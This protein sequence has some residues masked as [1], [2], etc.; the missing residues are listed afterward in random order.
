MRTLQWDNLQCFC[1]LSSAG[2]GDAAVN[3]ALAK[4]RRGMAR[5]RRRILAILGY[6]GF[7]NVERPFDLK[8]RLT[9][10]VPRDDIGI[11]IKG[12][13]VEARN[14]WILE[15]FWV[16]LATYIGEEASEDDCMLLI[17]K[18]QRRNLKSL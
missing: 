1:S 8:C 6:W 10:M 14:G 15:T 7:V 4:T 2:P 12:E 11:V 9:L 13:D 18:S 17:P 3:A 5:G 16:P